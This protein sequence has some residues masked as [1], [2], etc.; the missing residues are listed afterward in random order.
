M[1]VMYKKMVGEVLDETIEVLRTGKTSK[2]VKIGLTTWGS[3]IAPR[4]LVEGARLAMKREPGL[5]VSIIGPAP[6]CDLPVYQADTEDEVHT[7]LE[8]LLDGKELDGVVTMHYPFPIG[9]ATIGK[10]VTPARGKEMYIASTT[11]TADTDRIQAMIKNAVYGI[12]A[13]RA[14]GITNPTVGILNVDGAR[15][16]ERYLNTMQAN[17]Y[18]FSWGESRRAD[19]GHVLRGN[20][21]ILGSVDVVVCDTLTGNILMKLFSSFNSGGDYETGGYGYGPGIGD[22]FNRLIS[23]ISRASGTPVIANA[24]TYCA[25]MADGGLNRISR[26]Q[27]QKAKE[28]G[29][30]MPAAPKAE[31]EAKEDIAPPPAKVTGEQIPGIDILELE[32]AMKS[33][34]KEQVFASTGM[35][36]T[37]PVI[38]IAEEDKSKAIQILKA[39]RYL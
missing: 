14:D 3:E 15:Q 36:C 31:A 12:A 19:G 9:V 30:Q 33:L 13:A 23:I 28:A 22:N 6:E 32:E 27:I 7:M 39:N 24:L 8:T 5:Q 11:G 37:G 21:L 4:E 35:G 26:M 1:N 18:E 16:V 10:V 2:K 20:D 17:G 38:L 34:W 29:W 25:S